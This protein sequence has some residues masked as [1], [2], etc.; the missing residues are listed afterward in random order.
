MNVARMAVFEASFRTD[1]AAAKLATTFDVEKHVRAFKTAIDPSPDVDQQVLATNLKI[2][3]MGK[4]LESH[5]KLNMLRQNRGGGCGGR[6]DAPVHGARRGGGP[7]A[8]T[9]SVVC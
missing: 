9:T 2:I 5:T 8:R 6:G 7:P 3:E 1:C 4:L